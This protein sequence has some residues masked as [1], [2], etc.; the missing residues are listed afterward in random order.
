MLPSA[1]ITQGYE[2]VYDR[3]EHVKGLDLQVQSGRTSMTQ[4]NGGI[5]ITLNTHK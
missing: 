2:L 1:A 5:S 3:L 4:G